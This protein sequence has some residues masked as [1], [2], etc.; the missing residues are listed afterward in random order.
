M[1]IFAF[2]MTF[3]EADNGAFM[4]SVFGL[5]VLLL[6]ES[7][8]SLQEIE[9]PDFIF[10]SQPPFQIVVAM[11]SIFPAYMNACRCILASFYVDRK[12]KYLEILDSIADEKKNQSTMVNAIV[13]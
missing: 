6:C 9:L 4:Q 5:A 10:P 1:L 11:R 2:I 3:S 7:L 8:V 12:E 13:R